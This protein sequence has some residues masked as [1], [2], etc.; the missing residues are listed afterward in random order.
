MY[1]C[2][3]QRVYECINECVPVCLCGPVCCEMTSFFMLHV[4]SPGVWHH[5]VRCFGGLGM[6]W[7]YL[8]VVFGSCT[9]MHHACCQA[10]L[11]NTDGG[12]DLCAQGKTVVRG[13]QSYILLLAHKSTLSAKHV[14]AFHVMARMSSDLM[15]FQRK[16]S[17]QESACFCSFVDDIWWPWILVTFSYDHG[18][19]VHPHPSHVTCIH[20]FSRSHMKWMQRCYNNSD[21]QV[22]HLQ[23]HNHD[24]YAVRFGVWCMES[25]AVFFTPC[26]TCSAWWFSAFVMIFSQP[27]LWCLQS[28]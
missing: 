2:V 22:G 20:S 12:M 15:R 10:F 8:R 7:G 9:C 16:S 14:Q 19:I 6:W 18:I 1:N 17:P 27:M 3:C 4:A 25:H 5:G 24:R 11:D 21:K 13:V 26:V 28:V 23:V